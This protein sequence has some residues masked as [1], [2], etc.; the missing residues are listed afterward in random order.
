MGTFGKIILGPSDTCPQRCVI[1]NQNI[2]GLGNK[3]NKLG[4]T[5][6]AIIEK[7]IDGYFL[8]EIWQIKTYIRA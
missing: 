3:G 1:L 2:N 6:K 5:T 7:K 4:K 8:Q